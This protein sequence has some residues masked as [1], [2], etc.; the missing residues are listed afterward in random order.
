MDSYTLEGIIAF[1]NHKI[2]DFIL[3]EMTAFEEE[4]S[5]EGT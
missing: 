3:K 5:K 1:H 4:T 2:I